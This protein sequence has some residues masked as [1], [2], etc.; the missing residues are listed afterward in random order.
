MEP[1]LVCF[2]F[3]MGATYNVVNCY[4]Y[5]FVWSCFMAS[6]EPKLFSRSFLALLNFLLWPLEFSDCFSDIWEM[7]LNEVKD[8][9][10]VIGFDFFMCR[11]FFFWGYVGGSLQDPCADAVE[12]LRSQDAELVETAEAWGRKLSLFI[13]S[14]GL[15]GGWETTD[16]CIDVRFSEARSLFSSLASSH[17][18]CSCFSCFWSSDSGWRPS[19]SASTSWTFVGMSPLISMSGLKSSN[20]SQMMDLLV[21]GDCSPSSFCSIF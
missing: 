1:D 18:A 21:S 13:T 6:I 20:S 15:F 3:C 14:V 17:A 19:P 16:V 10:S 4:G 8:W 9:T 11:C 2:L 12:D 5:L 7:V